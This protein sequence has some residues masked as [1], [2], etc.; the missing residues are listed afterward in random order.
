MIL[1]VARP[2]L[3]APDHLALF[4]NDVQREGG[5]LR[6]GR[7]RKVVTACPVAFEVWRGIVLPSAGCQGHSSKPSNHECGSSRQAHAESMP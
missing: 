5:M 7:S 3:S 4:A 2:V 6:S 1:T